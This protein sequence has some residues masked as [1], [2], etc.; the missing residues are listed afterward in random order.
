MSIA[1]N[2][3]RRRTAIEQ[4]T[5]ENPRWNEFINALDKMGAK[6]GCDG[7]GTGGFNPRHIHRHAKTVMEDMGNVDIK[8]SLAF[9][10]EHG[11]YCDC[12]ILWNVAARTERTGAK[13][14]C[15]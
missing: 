3:E 15:K 12:E 8:G 2:D 4:M 1:T 5:P 10:C 13:G 7:D 11:G 14:E 9:F 6:F